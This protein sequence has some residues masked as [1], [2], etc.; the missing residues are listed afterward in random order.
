MNLTTL[1]NI[2][3]PILVA[4]GV[5]LSLWLGGCA[6]FDTPFNPEFDRGA[7]VPI[8]YFYV[9]SRDEMQIVCRGLETSIILGCAA[10]NPDPKGECLVYLYKNGTP[11]IKEHE[12]KHCR[13]G[14]WH[15]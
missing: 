7:N 14:R 15:S 1:R 13:Y 2:L 6:S 8:R 4:I 10:I 9:E 12:E 5:A 11:D 3:F